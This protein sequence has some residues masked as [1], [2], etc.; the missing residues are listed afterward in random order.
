LAKSKKTTRRKTI[1]W[2]TAQEIKTLRQMARQKMLARVAAK[3]LKRTLA[4][5]YMK[6]SSE[7]IS[8]GK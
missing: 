5:V 1:K 2:W 4:A 8:F 7:R 3:K 6:A